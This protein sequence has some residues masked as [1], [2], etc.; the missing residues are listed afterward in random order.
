MEKLIYEKSRPGRRALVIEKIGVK[1]KAPSALIP[2]KFVRKN[3][4]ALA[5]VSELEAVRHFVRLSHLNHAIDKAFYPL[6][7]C[8]MK[9]NPK[10]N[11]QMAALEGFRELHPM[12]PEEQIQGA[13]E[14]I[15]KLERS[16]SEVV[17]LPAVTL[18]PAAGAHGEMTGLLLIRAYFRAKG[19]TARTKVIV[20]D[21]AHGTNP[22]T[23]AMCGFDV[24]EIKSND[25]GLVDIDA[26]KAVLGPDTA[27]IMLTNP[28]TLGLFEEEIDTCQKLVHEAGGLLYYDGANLNAIMGL[29]RPGDMG[30]DVCHLNLHKTFST[31]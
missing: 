27:A 1:D 12:Q 30:F 2:A 6:G 15:Y 28:N 31:P 21:T 16:I 3:P 20:P 14:L 18:Q 19:D 7:S 26:L 25:R 17:G 10:I 24:V 5:E 13:L 9:Y 29:V 11:D 22:A 4:A 23:A 8:T